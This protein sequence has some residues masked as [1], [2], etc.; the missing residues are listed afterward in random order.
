[1][2]ARQL[3]ALKRN[4]VIFRL[5]GIL[6]LFASQSMEFLCDLLPDEDKPVAIDVRNSLK[7]ILF[8]VQES[9][10]QG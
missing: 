10:W 5:R 3:W 2:T 9:K 8:K 1:M 6:T 4:W 7:H